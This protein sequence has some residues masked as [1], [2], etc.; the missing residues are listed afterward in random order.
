MKVTI[1]KEHLLKAVQKVQG[2]LT[3][4]SLAHIS[5]RAEG[6]HLHVAATD[7]I[8][9]IYAKREASIQ[10]QGDAFVAAKLF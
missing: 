3:E 7:R 6:S 5:L 9:A 4:R 8:L 1:T 10:E 2:A